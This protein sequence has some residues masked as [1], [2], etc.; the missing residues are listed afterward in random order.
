MEEMI[1]ASGVQWMP[2]KSLFAD[3]KQLEEKNEEKNSETTEQQDHPVLTKTVRSQ[4]SYQVV[5]DHVRKQV[6]D[7]LFKPGDRL[8][9][10]RELAESLGISRN[11]V[12]EGLKV[13]QNIGVIEPSQGSGNYIAQNFDHTISEVLSFLYFL[14][15]M[16][17]ADVTEFR[18]MVE[19][20]AIH[21]A[22]KRAT[23]ELKEE[24]LLALDGLEKATSEE[25]RIH[26]DKELH[27]IA[28]LASGNDFLIANYEALT[29]FMEQYIQTMRQKIIRGMVGAHQLEASHRL[30]V[31]G[32]VESSEEKAMMGLSNHFGYIEKYQNI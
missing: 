17:E 29:S 14:K 6:L 10:E 18:W 26:Y 25:E 11:S 16:N 20:E 27:H 15:G 12:R 30:L 9:A 31:E 4:K 21:L 28:V 32:I 5:V 3:Q 13:L 22:V 2:E 7:G 19:R 23:P 1:E 8:P 24:L